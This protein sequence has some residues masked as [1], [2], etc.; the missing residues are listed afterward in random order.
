MIGVSVVNRDV[1]VVNVQNG[2]KVAVFNMLGKKVYS[3]V[4]NG[5]PVNFVLPSYGK[6]VVRAGNAS[7]TIVAK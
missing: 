2:D 3:S 5:N 1:S 7:K 6:Y 4:S